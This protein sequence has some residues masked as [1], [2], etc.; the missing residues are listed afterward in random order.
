M[1]SAHFN[2]STI[3]EHNKQVLN[4]DDKKCREAPESVVD[5]NVHKG[6]SHKT[7]NHHCNEESSQRDTL[8]NTMT[9]EIRKNHAQRVDGVDKPAWRPWNQSPCT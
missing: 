7:Q 4:D 1:S 6:K 3:Q 9:T 2:V 5:G 8:K